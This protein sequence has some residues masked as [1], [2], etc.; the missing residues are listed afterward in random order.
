MQ[1]SHAARNEKRKWS[2]T[3][4]RFSVSRGAAGL[5]SAFKLTAISIFMPQPGKVFWSREK[6]PRRTMCCT[7]EFEMSLLCYWPN[8]CGLKSGFWNSSLVLN[9]IRYTFTI[10]GVLEGLII[11]F[12][13]YN[14]PSVTRRPRRIKR[15][16][17]MLS[18]NCCRTTSKTAAKTS[19]RKEFKLPF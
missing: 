19:S 1:T 3:G 4:K 10:H 5:Q 17:Q 6:S 15:K 16:T 14:L 9:K 12:S 13:S 7:R 8:H 2:T 11:L 18:I